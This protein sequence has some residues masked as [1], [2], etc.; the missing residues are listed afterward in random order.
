M[1]LPHS[2]GK[3]TLLKSIIM[4]TILL[5]SSF[6]FYYCSDLQNLLIPMKRYFM[7]WA[8]VT[9]SLTAERMD[10]LQRAAD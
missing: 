10:V 3:S 9:Y 1:M 2:S 6:V 5:V 4:S 7:A 8:R